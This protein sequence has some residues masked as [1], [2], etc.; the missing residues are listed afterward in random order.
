M[1]SLKDYTIANFVANLKLVCSYHSSVSDICRKIQINRQQFMK[2]LSGSSFPSR[3]T[4]RRLCDF[5]GFDEYEMLMPHDQFRNIVRLKPIKSAHDIQI[6][7]YFVNLL[8]NAKRQKNALG[9]YI[10]YYYQYYNSFSRA[11]FILRS[12]IIVYN[13][14]DYTMYKRLE[15]LKLENDGSAPDVYKYV[16]ILATVGD[17]LHFIDQ[18]SITGH[19]LTHTIIYPSYRNRV[20]TLTGLTMGV[21]GSD[22]RL[23]SASPTVLEYLGRGIRLR[24]AIEGCRI[25]EN[26]SA[27]LPAPILDA[28]RRSPAVDVTRALQ[29]PPLI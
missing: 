21:S 2:Y 25:Y 6:P 12:L 19:E 28:L 17:R 15:R 8:A 9:K 4:F 18:E 1:Q 5:F 3:Y 22:Q 13:W 29:V 27:E 26:A 20:T 11:G 14:Q 10:G 23:I 7:T 16:G 24:E